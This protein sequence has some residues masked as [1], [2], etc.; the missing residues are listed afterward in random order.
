[1]M[2]ICP[3]VRTKVFIMK[4]RFS[5]LRSSLEQVQGG[6]CHV[7]IRRN[8]DHSS[9]VGDLS[10]PSSLPSDQTRVA[11]SSTHSYSYSSTS[12][13]IQAATTTPLPSR[14]STVAAQRP[15]SCPRP[16]R[17]PR[18]YRPPQRPARQTTTATT[19]QNAGAAQRVWPDCF[20]AAGS[21]A[22]GESLLREVQAP[23]SS[24]RPSAGSCSGGCGYGGAGSGRDTARWASGPTSSSSS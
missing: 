24:S 7:A 21:S 17:P 5:A 8:G 16:R 2:S 15:R 10:E 22:Q 13:S 11:S 3:N 12:A 20:G 6:L 9:Q 14:V 18:D 1:M 19:S 23:R 4:T